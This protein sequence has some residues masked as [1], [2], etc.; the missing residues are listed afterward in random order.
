[1]KNYCIA[2]IFVL[3]AAKAASYCLISAKNE[4]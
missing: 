3:L 4:F 2:Y 1:M